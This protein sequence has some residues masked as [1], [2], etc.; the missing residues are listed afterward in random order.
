MAKTRI[1]I[2]RKVN[3]FGDHACPHCRTMFI[4][5]LDCELK[6]GVTKCRRCGKKY[7]VP[8]KVAEIAKKNKRAYDKACDRV[9]EETLNV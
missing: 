1:K 4:D 9:I 6:A 3:H 2:V 8:K 7:R 5:A